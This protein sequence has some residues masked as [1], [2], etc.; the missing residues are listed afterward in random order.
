MLTDVDGLYAD[1]GSSYSVTV[2]GTSAPALVEL[3]V[4]NRAPVPVTGGDLLVRGEWLATL[5][6]HACA[7]ETRSNAT[8]AAPSVPGQQS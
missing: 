4:T 1:F 5:D 6:A 8:A 3:T 7:S 2:S